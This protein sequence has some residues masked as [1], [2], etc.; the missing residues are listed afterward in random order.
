MHKFS[1]I[2]SL[3]YASI[4]FEHYVLIIGGQNCIIQHLVSSH[5]WVAVWCTGRPPTNVM[6]PDAVQYNFDLL[7]MST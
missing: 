3:L 6:M 4:C 5:L 2:I 7:V 1:F